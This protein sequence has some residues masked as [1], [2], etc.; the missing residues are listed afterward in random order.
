M[1][2]KTKII[3]AL[4]ATAVIIIGGTSIYALTKK[5]DTIIPTSNEKILTN[6]VSEPDQTVQEQEIPKQTVTSE[7]PIL[8]NELIPMEEAAK[9]LNAIVEKVKAGNLSAEEGEVQM[10]AIRKR[11]APP[12]I[13]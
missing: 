6:T 5:S 1:E 4:I 2:N 13:K 8:P 10:S 3:I 12:T 11:L 9:Q 7:D